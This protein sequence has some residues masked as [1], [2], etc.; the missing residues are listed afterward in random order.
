MRSI[1]LVSP[2]ISRKYGNAIVRSGKA[3]NLREMAEKTMAG[4]LLTNSL[5]ACLHL[6]RRLAACGVPFVLG[7]GAAL[8]LLL[9]AGRATR[10]VRAAPASLTYPGCADTIRSAWILR[11][12]VKPSLASPAPTI[13]RHCP[14]G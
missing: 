11:Q 10:P 1:R 6:V 4:I 3:Q 2:K 5:L 9:S 12:P 13:H 14:R 8:I 7:T